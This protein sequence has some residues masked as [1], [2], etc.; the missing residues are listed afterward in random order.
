MKDFTE[1]I[2][3]SSG[4]MSGMAI[5]CE[6]TTG[7]RNEKDYV[8]NT[9]HDSEILSVTTNQSTGSGSITFYS[10]N[11][12]NTYD[13]RKDSTSG[14]SIS[15]DTAQTVNGTQTFVFAGGSMPTHG[16]QAWSTG[17]NNTNGLNFGHN[18]CVKK[19]K[20]ALSNSTITNCILKNQIIRCYMGLYGQNQN[21]T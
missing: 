8:S 17:K 4:E 10:D 12:G 15:L 7:T 20:Y 18:L 3:L 21:N 13:V 11:I 19:V 1:T 2:D 6:L 9:V 5:S 14:T 16:Q